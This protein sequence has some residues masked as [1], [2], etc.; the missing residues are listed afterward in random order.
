MGTNSDSVLDLDLPEIPDRDPYSEPSQHLVKSGADAWKVEEGR[1]ASKLLLPPGIREAVDTWRAADYPGLSATSL[2]LLRYWFDEDH[3]MP[4]GTLFRYYY[5]QREAVETI[6]YLYEERGLLDA[7]DLLEAFFQQQ[8]LLELQILTSTQGTRFFRRYIP[9]IAKEA[10]QELPPPGLPRYAVKMATGSGKTVVMALLIAWSYLHRRLEAGSSLASNF[11]VVAPNVIVYER[12]KDDFDSCRIFHKLPIIPSEWRHEFALQSILR[13]DARSPSPSGNLFLSNIQQIYEDSGPAPTPINP[14]AAILGNVP[15]GNLTAAAPMLDR[16]KRVSNLMVLNDEAHHV[17]DDDLAWSKTLIALH[18][19]LKAKGNRLTAW[20]DFSA[21]PKNQNGTY[22]PWTVVDY[23]LAQAV[24][25]R[26]VKTPLVIHQ[27]DK[28]DPDNYAHDE[29]GDVYSEWIAI[30]VDRW[31]RHVDEYKAIGEKPILFVMAEDTQDA[32]SIAERLRREPEFK[33][34]GS[35]LV[36][37]TKQNGEITKS[38]LVIARQQAKDVDKGT[39]KVKAIVSVMMLREGWDVRNVTVILGL[40]PFTAK[41]NIL[42][43]QAV[44]RGLRLIR[45]IPSGCNQ[46]V[47]LIGTNAFEQ[48]I[49]ELEKEGVG[50]KTTT[51][52]P[53]PADQI[54]PLQDRMMLDI[55]IPR[56]SPLYQRQ[57][58]RIEDFDPLALPSLADDST[59]DHDLKNRIDL[60]HGIVDVKVG[61]AEIEFNAE[62]VPPLENLLSALTCRV[63]RASKIPGHFAILY[64][65]IRDYVHHMCFG[66]TVPLDDVKLRRALNHGGLLDAIATLIGKKIGDLTATSRPVKL[67]GETYKLSDTQ[68]FLWRRMVVSCSKTIFNKVACYNHLEA[69]FAEFLD[70]CDDVERFA[71]LAEWFTSF[72]VQYLSK[73]GS[74][75]LYY[76]DFVAVQKTNNGPIF[77]ILETKG[78]EFEDTDSKATHMTRWCAEVSK[79]TGQKWQYLKIPQHVFT[80]FCKHGTTR[81]FQA[82]LSWRPHT[83]DDLL[84]FDSPKPANGDK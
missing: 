60:V 18:E 48:F 42:P 10:E 70:S 54:F 80:M 15:I 3:V 77:W 41:A 22:F 76:P 59:L 39:S 4:D 84:I 49:R 67:Q 66:R 72:N 30:A 8:D 61:S 51:T 75:R 45:N 13:G 14:I 62:N 65:K 38:D 57:I 73:T 21:T 52:P 40:R 17:H 2:R 5:C 6:V 1:R 71:A 7:A 47:E 12:L 35:L 23:P 28:A 11:L 44:G 82:L 58:K 24:E 26:I 79:E 25:D 56:T 16:I 69:S 50:V 37:H 55:E 74:I 53:R 81:S 83:Q 78:R 9:E 33:P 27:T 43:E 32:D 63:E 64:P 34:D 20:L 19:N 31:R 29:A 36:I 46:V 68:P